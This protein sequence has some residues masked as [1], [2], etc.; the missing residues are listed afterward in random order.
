MAGAQAVFKGPDC[1]R[2]SLWA[3]QKMEKSDF[4]K[5][6][7]ANFSLKGLYVEKIVYYRISDGQS[8]TKIWKLH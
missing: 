4:L 3:N 1:Q 8:T 6:G 2:R 7:N 5:K